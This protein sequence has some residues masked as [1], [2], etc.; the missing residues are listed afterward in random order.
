MLLFFFH[1]KNVSQ[2][3]F[4]SESLD[5]LAFVIKGFV[6]DR[7]R[8]DLIY[9]TQNFNLSRAYHVDHYARRSVS[10]FLVFTFFS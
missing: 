10:F 5:L 2:N 7:I 3:G 1:P 9:S 4:K 6:D 8:S